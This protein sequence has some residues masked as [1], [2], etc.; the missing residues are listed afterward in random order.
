MHGCVCVCRDGSVTVPEC[1]VYTLDL[2]SLAGGRGQTRSDHIQSD[3]E[4]RPGG[5]RGVRMRGGGRG[6]RGGDRQG[7]VSSQCNRIVSA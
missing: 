1:S 7:Q 4:G 2:T 3:Y 6:G 5:M